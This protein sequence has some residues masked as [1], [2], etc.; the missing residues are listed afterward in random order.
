MSTSTAVF[1]TAVIAAAVLF[2]GNAYARRGPSF[3]TPVPFEQLDSIGDVLRKAKTS[4]NGETVHIVYV[5]G[6]RADEWGASK[7]FSYALEQSEYVKGF[8]RETGYRDAQWKDG[9]GQ[10]AISYAGKPL[11]PGIDHDWK[12]AWKRSS[13]FM[14]RTTFSDPSKK[15]NF[16]VVV[17]EV[18]WWPLLMGLRCRAL[19]GPEAGLAGPSKRQIDLCMKDVD[20]SEGDP[21]YPWLK[22]EKLQTPPI[23][24]GAWANR[25]LKQEIMDWGLAD[26]VVALGPMRHYLRK[27][28]NWAADKANAEAADERIFISESLGSFVMMDAARRGGSA[29]ELIERTGHFYFLANQFALLEMARINGLPDS[30]EVVASDALLSSKES[31][32][33]LA[34]LKQ[35]G[36]RPRGNELVPRPA[37]IVAISDPSDALSFL[38][39]DLRDEHGNG[40]KVSNVQ[41]RF[42]GGPFGILASPIR[43]HRGGIDGGRNAWKFLLKENHK[44]SH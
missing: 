41:S 16:K 43:A 34:V 44:P 29:L 25:Y 26:A 42:S 22:G 15:T 7:F 13:P 20:I 23:G 14:V 31:S 24:R 40:T 35:A 33:A 5:H 3:G 32:S 6:M 2:G 37:Q 30:K 9:E 18:N 27:T 19:V 10:D 12:K 21:Y 28:I 38:V 36:K 17:D 4:G 8:K 1:I 39:P 11:L